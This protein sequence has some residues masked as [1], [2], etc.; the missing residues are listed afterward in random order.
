MRAS[1]AARGPGGSPEE[2]WITFR[3][4]NG[5]NT[6]TID[7]P[8]YLYPTWIRYPF[9]GT[10]PFSNGGVLSTQGTLD[11]RGDGW[12]NFQGKINARDILDRLDLDLY[13]DLYTHFLVGFVLNN[14]GYKREITDF[15]KGWAYQ[16]DGMVRE[17]AQDYVRTV[18]EGFRL[19]LSGTVMVY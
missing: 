4:T 12:F 6:Y 18:D 10:V 14:G 9:Q 11:L 5:P 1:A 17:L 2:K 19:L 7:Y 8:V 13:D 15:D 3:F 16:A